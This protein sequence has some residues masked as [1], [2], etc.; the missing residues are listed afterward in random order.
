MLTGAVLGI[1]APFAATKLLGIER[2]THLRTFD[3]FI[4]FQVTLM[5]LNIYFRRYRVQEK[6]E[7]ETLFSQRLEVFISGNAFQS[8]G[9]INPTLSNRF[10]G[11]IN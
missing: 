4:L 11:F 8:A 3:D 2:T 10:N 9:K 1:R 5:G 6:L 7:R